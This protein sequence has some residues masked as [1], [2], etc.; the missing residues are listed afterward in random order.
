M[1]ELSLG[2]DDGTD[3]NLVFSKVKELFPGAKKI[4]TREF[5]E[6]AYRDDEMNVKFEFVSPHNVR[7]AY[8]G[9]EWVSIDDEEFH[10]FAGNTTEEAAMLDYICY[11]DFIWAEYI[12]KDLSNTRTTQ[13][14][15]KNIETIKSNVVKLW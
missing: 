10:I 7:L 4:I 1:N 6:L 5:T 9:D 14:L 2:F 13:G 3:T 15:R 11:L 8:H 12:A